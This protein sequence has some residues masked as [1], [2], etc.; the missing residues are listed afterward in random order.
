MEPKVAFAKGTFDPNVF[1]NSEYGKNALELPRIVLEHPGEPM[2]PEVLAYWAARGARKELYEAGTSRAWSVFTPLS[3]DP[4][5]KYPLIYCSHGGG[6]DQYMAETYGYNLLVSPMRAIC[7]YPQNGGNANQEIEAEFPRILNELEERGYPIDRSRVY[8]VGFSA[9]SVASLRLAMSC[10]GLLAGI[11]PVP[12]ANSFRGGILG[13]K[14]PGYAQAHGL[15]MPLICCG[16]M[17]DGGDAWPLSEE[18]EF[19]NFNRWMA[20]VGKAAGYRPMSMARA[21][22]LAQGEDTVKRRFRLDFDETWIGFAEGTFWYCGQFYDERKVPIARFQGIEGLPHL[23]CKT[24]ARE[25]FGY[26]SQFARDLETGEIIYTS[27]NVN[28][29]KY[30]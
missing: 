20:D 1:T 19:D 12:G 7:V 22:E 2:H 21:A 18:G 3:M 9:G 29:A 17:Q 4:A 14:L 23:H 30:S 13:E 24:Q 5:A 10:P 26:L 11:G 27:A 8:A 28:H 25:I 6:E 16:G 15:Q